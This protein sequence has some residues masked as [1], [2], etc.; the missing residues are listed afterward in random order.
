MADLTVT[1]NHHRVTTL[2][3]Q[4]ENAFITISSASSRRSPE[5]EPTGGDRRLKPTTSVGLEI[6][7]GGGEDSAETGPP[8]HDVHKDRRALGSGN[9]ADP[10][11][12]KADTQN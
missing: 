9:I 1:E 8:A 5:P 12:Q 10:F 3:R 6:I 4:V 2:S 7:R 11:A